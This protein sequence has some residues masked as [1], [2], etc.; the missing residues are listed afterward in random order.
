MEITVFGK[1]SDDQI[2]AYRD[3][4]SDLRR[5]LESPAFDKIDIGGVGILFSPYVFRPDLEIPTQNI[6]RLSRREKV[7]YIAREVPFQDWVSSTPL[8]RLEMLCRT[9]CDSIDDVRRSLI[10]DE[11]KAAIKATVNVLLTAFKEGHRS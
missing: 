2:E 10:S 11:A 6:S 8:E 1:T 4:T 5:I 9:F 7:L 3:C